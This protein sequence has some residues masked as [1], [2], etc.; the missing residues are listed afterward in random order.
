MKVPEDFNGGELHIPQDRMGLDGIFLILRRQVWVILVVIICIMGAATFYLQTVE[1]RFTARATLVLTPSETRINRTAAQLESFDVSRPIIETELDVLRS[2]EFAAELS[3]TLSLDTHPVFAPSPDAPE[4]SPTERRNAVIDQLLNSYAVFRS[5]ESLAIE[6]IAETP[7][8]E[9]SADIANGVAEVY[10]ARS[11]RNQREEIQRSINFLERRIDTMATELTE[12]EVEFAS[13]VRGNSLDDEDRLNRLLAEQMR[14]QAILQAINGDNRQDAEITRSQ[15]ALAA[16]DEQLRQ[17]TTATLTLGRMQRA[18]ELQEARY[19]NAVEQLNE[20]ETQLDFV[21]RSARHVT[22]AS[23]PVEAAWPNQRVALALC[24]VASLIIAFVAALLVDSLNRRVWSEADVRRVAGLR[25]IG[26]VSRIPRPGFMMSRPTPL[27]YL[28]ND[29]RSI[30]HEG[31]RGIL[32][33][34]LSDH[35]TRTTKVLMVTSSLPEDGKSTVSLS[36]AGC[37]AR[38][39]LN[40][41]IIDLDVHQQ[42]VTQLSGS[43]GE[44]LSL[45]DLVDDLEL[46]NISEHLE[47]TGAAK[48]ASSAKNPRKQNPLAAV[49]TPQKLADGLDLIR[50]DARGRLNLQVL[51]K[52]QDT[53]MPALRKHYD[54]IV[55]DTPPVLVLDD[56]CRLSQL[57]EAVLVVVRWGR[58]KS[59][60][61]RETSDRLRR[62]GSTVVGTIFNDV[63][64]KRQ[65]RYRTGSYIGSAAYARY[66]ASEV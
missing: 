58:T 9:L 25:N 5:G 21:P 34:W 24:F 31:L 33:L 59:D 65:R 44:P 37:A 45:E 57:A 29:A 53:L 7:D 3:E 22:V 51:E 12:L 36:L 39:G 60:D 46:E 19:Q 20:L 1:K 63:D 26:S 52:A 41:L 50:I 10:I 30:F 6:I 23:V 15:E 16:I 54:L 4:L 35:G 49:V 47:P 48:S 43:D 13:F 56:A 66:R 62:R 32:T 11:A 27:E 55:L 40:V 14:L 64:P 17:H 28:A 8:P 18:M 38:D 2:R 61:L 42:G